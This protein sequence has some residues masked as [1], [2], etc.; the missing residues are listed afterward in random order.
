M[1]HQAS[2]AGLTNF[3]SS[4]VTARISPNQG[5]TTTWTVRVALPKGPSAFRV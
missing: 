5:V 2:G 4:P 1:R 3:L